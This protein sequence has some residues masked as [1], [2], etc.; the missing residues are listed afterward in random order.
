M[1]HVEH[2]LKK[3]YT[4]NIYV[5]YILIIGQNQQIFTSSKHFEK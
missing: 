2:T 1:I 4:G 3:I 5:N